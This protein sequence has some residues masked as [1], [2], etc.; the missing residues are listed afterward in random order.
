[1]DRSVSSGSL[2]CIDFG[3]G[4]DDTFYLGAGW[5]GDEPCFR[6]AIGTESELWIR[7]PGSEGDCL[8][9][10]DVAPLVQQPILS[11]QH[12]SVFVRGTLIG[13]TALAARS[14]LGLR[15]PASVFEGPGPVKLLFAHPDAARPSDLG[16]GQDD[17]RLALSFRRLCLSRIVGDLAP[18]RLIDWKGVALGEVEQRTGLLAAELMLKFESIGDN[19]EFGLVQR[20]CGAEPLGLLRFSNLEL[21]R[22]IWGLRRGFEGLGGVHNL[23]FWLTEGMRREYV[24][25]DRQ[26]GL[27]FHTFLYEN[28]VAQNKL[29]PQQA[30]RLNFLRRKFLEDLRNGEKILVCKRNATLSGSD[31]LALHAE[32]NRYGTNTLLWVTAS[33]GDHTPGTVDRVMPGLLRGYIDRFAPYENAHD[34][35]LEVWLSI[36]VNAFLLNRTASAADD[37]LGIT[38]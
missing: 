4:G 27:V 32:L 8:L 13:W 20:R 7:N 28:E 16:Q 10:F 33:D 12:L 35:S 2:L 15:I 29:L 25:R 31:M 5:S 9:E 6:W 37:S 24:I 22:L 18:G 19:C 23:D 26:Y 34:L 1:M 3:I 21:H 38:T 36:C 30:E 17:R 14:N 11:C